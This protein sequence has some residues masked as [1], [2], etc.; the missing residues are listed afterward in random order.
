MQPTSDDLSH[1]ETLSSRVAALNLLDLGLEHLDI[2]VEHSSKEL[3]LVIK[4]CGESTWLA[5]KVS[6]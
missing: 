5:L 1:D 4:E 6:E 3:D 2:H